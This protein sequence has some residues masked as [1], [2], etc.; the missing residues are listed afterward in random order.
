MI[1][2]DTNVFAYLYLPGDM[3]RAARATLQR[4]PDWVAPP[5][6]R[7]ELRNV[8]A[9]WC[10]SRRLSVSDAIETMDA[11]LDHMAGREFD[12]DSAAVLRLAHESGCA[13]S[14]CEFVAL[15]LQLGVPLVTA[16]RSV[17]GAFPDCAESLA[18]F[19]RAKR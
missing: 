3:T 11:V 18:T 16:D 10:R 14:D 12:V 15:A 19:G 8:L 6:W 13:A 4:D 2:G 17:L 1:V 7:S 5:L 9:T